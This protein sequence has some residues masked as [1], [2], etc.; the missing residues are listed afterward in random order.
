MYVHVYVYVYIYIYIYVCMYTYTHIHTYIQTIDVT[1]HRRLREG[2][3]QEHSERGRTTRTQGL[4]RF[5]SIA[6][7]MGGH[8]RNTARVASKAVLSGEDRGSTPSLHVQG[9]HLSH[10][11]GVASGH[12]D[13]C[14][15]MYYMYSYVCVYIMYIHIYIYIYTYTH[16]CV[17]VCVY[18]YIYIFRVV[19][20]THVV[21]AF[22]ERWR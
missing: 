4:E 6:V 7:C 5:Y 22:S 1:G 15:F 16:M 10:L 19:G 12:S 21:G 13:F 17:Y 14:P 2:D 3:D 11:L 8:I 18:I 9:T 20:V